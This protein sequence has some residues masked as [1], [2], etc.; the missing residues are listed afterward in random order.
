MDCGFPNLTAFNK[1]F[2]EKY[3]VSPKQYRT[4]LKQTEQKKEK[5]DKESRALAEF[6]LLDYFEKNNHIQGQEFD[7]TEQV[8]ADASE[9]TILEKNWNKMI[10]IGGICYCRKKF[11]II[12][13]FYAR[14]LGLN[15]YESGICMRHVCISMPETESGSTISVVWISVW[16]F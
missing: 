7:E 8:V 13:C 15:M 14:P 6:Q 10:N 12:R 16:T 5:A 3:Q 11:R 1:A 4:E 9:Y 2:R